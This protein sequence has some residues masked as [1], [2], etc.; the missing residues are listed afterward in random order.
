MLSIVIFFHLG[1]LAPS[2]NTVG[3]VRLQDVLVLVK[4]YVLLCQ[5]KVEW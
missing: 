4:A 2:I 5:T 3:K 1:P